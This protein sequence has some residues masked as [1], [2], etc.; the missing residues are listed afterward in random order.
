MVVPIKPTRWGFADMDMSTIRE[1]YPQ[2]S[3]LSDQELADG[4]Y[5]KFYS[6]MPR[7]EFDVKI[8]LSQP[9]QEIEQGQ[10]PSLQAGAPEDPNMATA[11]GLA[12]DYNAGFQ[13]VNPVS[14]SKAQAIGALKR[15]PDGA[16]LEIVGSM[17]GGLDGP[18]PA[19]MTPDKFIT[20]IDPATG[21]ELIYRK[22]PDMEESAAASTGRVLGVG[23]IA[24]TLPA[25]SAKA[26]SAAVAAAPARAD[27]M[28]Q[29]FKE[30]KVTPALGMRGGAAARLAGAL[31]A[32]PTGGGIIN[33]DAARALREIEEGVGRAKSRFGG[34]GTTAVEGGDALRRGAD[35]FLSAF[36]ADAARRYARVDRFVGASQPIAVSE[37]AQTMRSVVDKFAATPEIAKQLG[38]TKWAK[39]LDDFDAAGGQIPWEALSEIRSSVGRTIGKMTGVLADQDQARVKQVY[40]ALTRDMEAGAKAAG[41]KA[42]SAWKNANAAYQR[43]RE[44]IDGA[45]DLIFKSASP[46]QSFERLLN[47]GKGGGQSANLGKLR[48]IK[49]AMPDE[50]WREVTSTVIAKLGD[51][52]G[53]FSAAQFATNWGKMTEQARATMFTGKGVSA[54]AYRELR[55][56]VKTMDAAKSAGLEINRS[57][58]GVVGGAMGM[59]ALGYVEPTTLIVSA[60]GPYGLAKASTSAGFLRAMNAAAKGSVAGLRSIAGAAK[61]P[62]SQEAAL[63]IRALSAEEAGTS[64]RA[65]ETQS[66]PKL[67][68]PLAA[69]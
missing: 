35:E 20:Q 2:Y 32:T 42:Y 65:I 6:D 47:L 44:T 3:D 61:H 5:R 66:L 4:L 48:E 13:G 62:L 11:A 29:A 16:P 22:T 64:P 53:E 56:L 7:A 10:V 43:G 54:A 59:A 34:V 28:A 38:V 17:D 8:G 49:A 41:P 23:A 27:E 45:L 12:N 1:K 31:E 14:V 24:P 39:W 19:W 52:G 67:P 60:L 51:K 69:Q 15:G 18:V 57:R 33:A 63:I 9:E 26:T 25:R 55:A 68:A 36:E 46:E 30:A 50:Q 37:S 40:A 21:R 58:S